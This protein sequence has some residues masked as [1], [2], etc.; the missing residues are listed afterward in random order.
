MNWDDFFKY[1]IHL[2]ATLFSKKENL[3]TI[4]SNLADK[5][6]SFEYQ[7]DTETIFGIL[8]SQ[9]ITPTMSHMKPEEVKMVIKHLKGYPVKRGPMYKWILKGY[10]KYK[11]LH[12]GKAY[13]FS[14]N[15]TSLTELF[16]F[17]KKKLTPD[18]QKYP[19]FGLIFRSGSPT[20]YGCILHPH[21]QSVYKILEEYD[22]Q[23]KEV[24]NTAAEIYWLCSQMCLC[25][26][27]SSSVAE[28]ISLGYLLSKQKSFTYKKQIHL[29]A[30]SLSFYEFNK[31]YANFLQPKEYPKPTLPFIIQ[32]TKLS[33]NKHQLIKKK[34]EEY[35]EL[36]AKHCKLRCPMKFDPNNTSLPYYYYNIAQIKGCL[37]KTKL[38]Y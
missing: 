4:F 36:H 6:H 2:S 31:V 13:T 25:F 27:G 1:A 9:S 20:H 21:F 23:K 24:M 16:I 22:Y 11:Y 32:F 18:L 15:N 12:Q 26:R 17:P 14:Y 8:R 34:Y 3:F 30:L 7:K 37:N 28:L 29:H 10:Y 33:K 19:Y 35:K 5:R 38:R